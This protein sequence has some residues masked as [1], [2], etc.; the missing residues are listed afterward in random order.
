MLAAP[1]NRSKEFLDELLAHTTDAA[2]SDFRS[3]QCYAEFERQETIWADFLKTLDQAAAEDYE[4]TV[5]QAFAAY[6]QLLGD[7]F[8][9]LGLIQAVE[10]YLQND[11]D[12]GSPK[13]TPEAIIDAENALQET[14]VHFMECLS[15]VNRKIYAQYW[16]ARKTAIDIS[17][18]YCG[19]YG[20]EFAKGLLARAGLTN[21]QI[22]VPAS[23][24]AA[25]TN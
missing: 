18:T 9:T 14:R 10:Q 23:C 17:S 8:W 21:C 1:K 6:Q 16:G 7:Y 25:E 3:T 20:M 22:Q 12:S 11:R 19:W 4:E 5:E 15:P 13:R 2:A 24:G